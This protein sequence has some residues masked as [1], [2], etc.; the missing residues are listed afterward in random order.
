MHVVETI[1]WIL[2]QFLHQDLTT[3]MKTATFTWLGTEGIDQNERAGDCGPVATKFLEMH[4][5]G[6]E[7]EEMGEMVNR[8]VDRIRQKY[9]MDCYEAFVGKP[10]KKQQLNLSMCLC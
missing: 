8:D 1:T 9:A 7:T 10:G 6:L 5:W 4:A 2:K 3:R